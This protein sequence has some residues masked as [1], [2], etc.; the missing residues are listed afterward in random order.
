[1]ADFYENLAPED[2]AILDQL[3]KLLIELRESHM[4][5]LA[6]YSVA[7]EDDLFDRL[8]AGKL[9]EHTAYEDYLGARII[10]STRQAVRAQLRDY[11][12][13]ID[14]ASAGVHLH[15]WLSDEVITRYGE[16]L[17]GEPR[18]SLDALTL[19]F[20]SGLAVELRFANANEYSIYW[21]WPDGQGRI[22]TAPGHGKLATCPNH[23]HAADG[24]LRPDPLTRPGRE[25]WE[26][27]SAVL[28]ALLQNPRLDTAG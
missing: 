20:D 1:M 17:T 6:R 12:L 19:Q 22:D 10:E 23:L 4:T 24:S 25:P 13:Q 8:R 14:P 27:L 5:L 2:I 28:D 11:M 16:R 3:A 21:Q 26:N 7:S 9:A 18:Q 15:A